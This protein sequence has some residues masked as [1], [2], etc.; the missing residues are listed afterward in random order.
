MKKIN[1]NLLVGLGFFSILITLIII[2]KIFSPYNVTEIDVSN[3]L[4][5]PTMSHLFGTDKFGRDIFT[6]IMEGGKI[7]I[8]VGISSISIGVISGSFLGM[9]SGYIGGFVDEIIMRFVDAFMSFPGILF[10]LMMVTAFGTGTF[11]TIL[12]IGI[13]SVPHFTRLA[14]GETLKEKDMQ[15]RIKKQLKQR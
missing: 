15:L 12:V 8:L 1:K 4:S 7:A 3:K 5:G 2:T 9:Y 14:R 11:N 6:R 13:M 10:A